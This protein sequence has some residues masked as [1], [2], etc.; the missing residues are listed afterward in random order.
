MAQ[1]GWYN[2]RTPEISLATGNAGPNPAPVPKSPQGTNIIIINMKTYIINPDNGNRVTIDE[3][4]QE[5]DPKRAEL[6]AIENDE[7]KILLMKKNIIPGRFSFSR[8]QEAAAA[9]KPKNPE[10]LTFRCPTRKEC[11]DIWDAHEDGTL[12]E[13]IELTG[14]SPL[15]G[16]YWTCER[17]FA[18]RSTANH[19]WI[20][21]GT[22]G[23]LISSY[24]N[25]AYR[26]QA[27]TLL[28]N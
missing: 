8:A 9:F 20:F 24:V 15:E 21:S 3:W 23:S 2:G 1:T 6:I 26:C 25:Y 18:R 16:W 12:D 27:V 11:M 14:G 19:A 10:G 5:S 22:Y 17:W 7:G 28:T 13:A 4:R